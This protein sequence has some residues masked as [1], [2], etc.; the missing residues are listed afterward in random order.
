M[1]YIYY[2]YHSSCATVRKPHNIK[3]CDSKQNIALIEIK[4][5]DGD[6]K[7][8]VRLASSSDTLAPNTP[9]TLAAIKS[10][11]PEPHATV[12]PRRLTNTRQHS[13]D[14]VNVMQALKSFPPGSAGGMTGLRPVH[15]KEMCAQSVGVAGKNLLGSLANFCNIIME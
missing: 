8:A 13:F 9:E 10:K 14:G 11:H 6:I 4:L 7:G 3:E 12:V 15:L 2:I 1:V 5:T